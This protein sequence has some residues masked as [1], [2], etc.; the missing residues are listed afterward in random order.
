M[1]DFLKAVAEKM[2]VKE[3]AVEVRRKKMEALVTGPAGV[4]LKEDRDVSHRPVL[5]KNVSEPKLCT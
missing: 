2:G 5:A 1:V 3:E 4:D